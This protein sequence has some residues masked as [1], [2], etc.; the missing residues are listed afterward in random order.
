MQPPIAKKI[1]TNI[2]VHGDTRSDEY[3][4]MRDRSDPDVEA[5]LEAENAYTASVMEPAEEL[6]EKLYNEILGRINEDDLSV[7]VKVDDWYYQ[8]RTEKGRSYPVYLRRRGSKDGPEEI[9]LDANLLAEGHKYFRIGNFDHSPNHKLLAYSVDTEGDEVYTT[10]VKDL[11]TGA[12]LPDTITHSYY[13]LAWAN[14]NRTFF[15]TQVDDTKRPYKVFRHELGSAED[16]LVFHEQDARF[17]LSVHKTLSRQFLYISSDSPLTSEVLYAR[18]DAPDSQF[19]VLLPRKP[20]VEYD[21]AHQGDFFYIRTNEGAQNFRLMR[22]PVANPSKDN[23]TEIVPGRDAVTIEGVHGFRDFLVIEERE[24]G[25]ET[26]HIARADAPGQYESVSF[27]EPVYSAAVVGNAEYDTHTVRFSYT[28]LVTPASVY[29]YNVD[30][31]QRELLKQQQVL[32]GYDPSLYQ[33]E[34]LF[35][36]ASDGVEVPVSLVYRKGIER[37]GANPLLLYGYGAYGLSSDVSFSSERLSLL[38][39]RFIFAIAHIRGGGDLGK[40]WHDGGKLLCKKN[41]FTDFIVCAELLIAQGYTSPSLLAI[42]G[43]SAGGLLMGAVLNL[44]P[45]LFHVCLTRVPFVDCVNTMLD[46]T[47]PL[48]IA[49]YEEWGNPE[50]VEYYRYIRSYSPYDNV[51]AQRYPTM[52]VTSGI[53]DPRVSYWEPSKWVARLR[54]IKTDGNVILLRMHMGAGHFGPSGRYDAIR[55]T[56]FQYAFLLMQYPAVTA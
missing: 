15:Y 4:W 6:R 43:G 53:N 12:L 37:Q 18:A 19:Q 3:F 5:Y 14:D 20:E 45:D 41:T 13:S 44:R 30:T 2:T 46:P 38:D 16:T 52:L 33:S 25:L 1:P 54:A 35:A 27:P 48:T 32:G 55:Q 29:D 21:I 42:N 39:R 22:T 9:L 51:T 49:E 17:E 11:E 31:R 50:N 24:R 56:A 23:W 26:I 40:F 8:T 10:Y 28:S 7:P 47:L 36:K 34:R